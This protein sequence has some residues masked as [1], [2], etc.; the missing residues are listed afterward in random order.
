MIESKNQAHKT[1]QKMGTFGHE[2]ANQ[3][4]SKRKGENLGRWAEAGEETELGDS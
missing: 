2:V 3:G 1:K 4:S